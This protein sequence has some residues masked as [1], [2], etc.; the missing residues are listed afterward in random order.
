MTAISQLQQIVNS[1][2]DKILF[3]ESDR[4]VSAQQLLAHA[5]SLATHLAQHGITQGQQVGIYMSRGLDAAIAIYAVQFIG[6]VYVPLD[7]SHPQ[8]RNQSIIVDAQCRCVIGSVSNLEWVERTDTTYLDFYHLIKTPITA[9]SAHNSQPEDRAAILYTSGSSGT[10]KGVVISHR[11][12]DA[13]SD[14][15]QETFSITAYDRIASLAPFSFDLSLFDLFAAPGAGATT[16]FIPD[17]L[18]LAPAKLVDWLEVNAISTWYT[19]PSILTFITMKGG[20]ASKTLPQLRQILFAGEVFPHTRL[21]QLC[22]L[23]PKTTFYNLFGP[24]ETNVC[25]YWPV[26]RAHIAAN[27]FIPI[28]QSACSAELKVDPEN[29]E[30]LVKGPCLMSGYWNGSEENLP[31]DEQG[32]FHTG[33][34]VS[35]NE[36]QNYH[37]HGRLDRMIK[38][39]GYRIEPA[40]VENILNM[41]P[42]VLA[43]AVISVPD[44]VSGTRLVAVISTADENEQILRAHAHQKLASYMRPA[45]YVFMDKLPLLSNGKTDYQQISKTL[46]R[47]FL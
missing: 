21:S 23:L 47:E 22:N 35:A 13:F 43:S 26:D 30:L 41:A 8:E 39:S 24:T 5:A 12:I 10:P 20:L 45:H 44:P 1:K 28:G 18:K 36:F 37:Y 34:K 4:T 29:K 2:P 32:W 46:E 38:S 25:L 15:A 42:G 6:A 14:W 17:R 33:D 27:T 16:N 19:V 31:L 11:A 3:Q 40:E 9:S 7:V